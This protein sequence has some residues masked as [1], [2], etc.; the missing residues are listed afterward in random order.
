MKNLCLL[1][2]LGLSP[3]VH[4]KPASLIVFSIRHP[5]SLQRRETESVV[6]SRG[7]PLLSGDKIIVGARGGITFDSTTGTTLSIIGPALLIL[8]KGANGASLLRVEYGDIY[9]RKAEE[10]FYSFESAFF[11]A[12]ELSSEAEFFYE[13]PIGSHFF[14]VRNLKGRFALGPTKVPENQMLSQAADKQFD[15]PLREEDLQVCRDRHFNNRQNQA[16]NIV[17][18]TPYDPSK[19]DYLAGFFEVL[20]YIGTTKFTAKASNIGQYTGFV[21]ASAKLGTHL[22]PALPREPQRRDFLYSLLLRFGIEMGAYSG[23][24][25][26]NATE[27]S[28]LHLGYGNVFVGMGFHGLSADVFYGRPVNLSLGGSYPFS[29][30]KLYGADFQYRIDL[31]GV[32]GSETGL[33]L[34][35]RV[36]D[37]PLSEMTADLVTSAGLSADTVNTLNF[38][39]LVAVSMRF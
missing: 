13:S 4:G 27:F 10:D 33:I 12:V 19:V 16:L 22:Y 6:P 14:R 24:F 18:D 20:P 15:A 2:L 7:M 36:L 34:G 26:F 8:S 29:I 9:F 39:P 11:G 21:G 25:H 38:A 30:K 32:A 17:G 37:I 23:N 3:F 1:V 35:L 28:R 5:V 31:K